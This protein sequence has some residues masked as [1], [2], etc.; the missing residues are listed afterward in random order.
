MKKSSINTTVVLFLLVSMCVYLPGGNVVAYQQ[1]EP[2]PPPPPEEPPHQQCVDFVTGGGWWAPR[3]EGGPTGRVN[4]GFNAGGRSANN[5]EIKGHF[6]LKDHSDGTHVSGVNVLTYQVCVEGDSN[7]RRFSGDAKVNGNPG[8]SYI[9]YVCDYGEPGRDD[10]I[11]VEVTGPNGFFYLADNF[12]STKVCDPGEGF[13]G[14]LDGGNL[15]VHK[16][17]PTC[18]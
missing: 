18:P 12:D 9:V 10:R 8:Y 4:V 16:A 11:R 2:P 1:H 13:C 7:C 17:C 15:Q 5:P 14:D 3:F 6:N